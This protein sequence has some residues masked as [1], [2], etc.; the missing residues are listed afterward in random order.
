MR[1]ETCFLTLLLLWALSPALAGV[2]DPPKS[3][4]DSTSRPD[5][6]SS[7]SRAVFRCFADG[8]YARAAEL[9]ETH[10]EDAPNDAVMLYNLACARSRMGQVDDAAS[11][12]LRALRAG[13]DDF[14]TMRDDP[15]LAAL[16]GHPTFDAIFERAGRT[17]GK[18]ARNVLDLWRATYGEEDYRCERDDERRIAY[19]T[20]LDET[21]H[22]EMKEMIQQ[23]ADQMIRDLFGEPPDDYILIVVPTGEDAEALF[24][25][26]GNVGGIYRHA[27]R[28]LIA[29]NIGG[30]LRHEFAHAL[31]YAHMER[32]GLT[33]AHRMWVQEGLAALYED[34]Q[35]LEDGSIRF[36]PNNRHNVVK[37]RARLD[38][39]AKW[40]D[41][42]AMSG[43]QLMDRAGRLYPQVRSIFRFLADRGKLADW[44]RAY[45]ATFPEDPDGGKAF[46]MTFRQPVEE[47]EQ[48]WREWVDRQPS[49]DDLIAPNDAALGIRSE[50]GLRNDGVLITEVLPGSAARRGGL[51]VGDVIVSVDG[52][53]TRSPAELI[54]I[55]GSK[56]VGDTLTVRIRR[57]DRYLSIAVTLRPRGPVR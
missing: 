29:R 9:I 18:E 46:E 22:C 25:G 36:L 53:S 19:A 56:R 34:Y 47:V 14:D 7:L 31:H 52:R 28:R 39:L 42:F 15:D 57:R 51:T 49:F 45:V 10:L 13:F 54:G 35:W 24:P 8:D 21:S 20:A 26:Q 55:I 41:L 2:E 27:D 11:A 38:R 1:A 30:S 43:E 17:K 48:A 44:Y 40:S 12:L 4:A 16:R 3:G 6:A 32:L 37:N 23:Q 33:T 50:D 5:D